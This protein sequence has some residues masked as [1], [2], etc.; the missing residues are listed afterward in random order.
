MQVTE[1]VIRYS[2]GVQ[3]EIIASSLTEAKKQA[4]R[5]F[6]YLCERNGESVTIYIDDIPIA[7]KRHHKWSNLVSD[8]TYYQN[9]C[10]TY[11]K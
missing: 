5:L 9:C 6:T 2:T 8:W 4:S 3:H 7:K 1:F 11:S 10:N